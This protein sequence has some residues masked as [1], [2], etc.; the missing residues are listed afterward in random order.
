VLILYGDVPLITAPQIEALIRLPGPRTLNVATCQLSD[1]TGYGRMIRDASGAAVAIR[2]QRDLKSAAEHAVL[3]VNTGLY[4]APLGELREALGTLTR[5]NAQGEYYLTD[6]VP[7]FAGRGGVQTIDVGRDAVRGVNDRVQLWE[8]QE[9]MNRR[10][11]DAHRVNGVSIASGVYVDEGVTLDN[12]V[13]IHAGCHLR[14]KTSVGAGAVL[15]VGCVLS[16]ARVEAG[17]YLA[18]YSV[19]TAHRPSTQSP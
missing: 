10:I 3:E 12:D 17:A 9:L 13:V 5:D 7:F 8:A 11:V 14:G 2:E 1:P 6:I 18:P 15:D 16:D 4:C 19:V